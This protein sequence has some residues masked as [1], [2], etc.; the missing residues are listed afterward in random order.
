MCTCAATRGAEGSQEGR[1]SERDVNQHDLTA[2][3][4]I[5]KRR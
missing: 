4:G 5:L 1:G 3:M 2:L